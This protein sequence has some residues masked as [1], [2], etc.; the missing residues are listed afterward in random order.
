MREEFLKSVRIMKREK[1]KGR[2]SK[3]E[4]QEAFKRYVNRDENKEKLKNLLG[5]IWKSA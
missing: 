1:K 3:G 2:L 5:D 4:L